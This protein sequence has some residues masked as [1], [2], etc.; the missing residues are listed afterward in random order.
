MSGGLTV[1]PVIRMRAVFSFIVGA[2]FLFCASFVLAEGLG[3]WSVE[4]GPNGEVLLAKKIS[5]G[6]EP[7]RGVSGSE[8]YVVAAENA[9]KEAG[10]MFGFERDSVALAVPSSATVR[11]GYAYVSFEQYFGS[12]PVYGAELHVAIDRKSIIPVTMKGW[13]L[14]SASMPSNLTPG[15]SEGQSK[16]IAL[17]VAKGDIG[18]FGGLSASEPKLLILPARYIGGRDEGQ[19]VL[20]YEVHVTAS[21]GGVYSPG[22]SKLYFIDAHS[23][24]VL[25]DLLLTRMDN[26]KIPDCAGNPGGT[27]CKFDVDWGAEDR[28]YP[29]DNPPGPGG[30]PFTIP[31]YPPGRG[32]HPPPPPGY[33]YPEW[34]GSLD[35]DN[36]FYYLGALN[37]Y[38]LNVHGINGMNR[39]G[40]LGNGLNPKYHTT[41]TVSFTYLDAA[42]GWLSYCPNAMYYP[43]NP[44]IYF[45][46]GTVVPDMVAHELTHGLVGWTYLDGLGRPIGML[47]QGQSGALEEGLCDIQ[48]EIFEEY[49]TGSNEE[50]IFG[51]LAR[52]GPYRNLKDPGSLIDYNITP[53]K[54][55]PD[56]FGSPNF[57]CG[58]Q[59]NYGVHHNATVPGH[60]TQLAV[61]GGD[62]NNCRISG[63]GSDKVSK[64]W[65]RALTAPPPHGFMRTETFN[66]AYVTLRNACFA[67]AQENQWP[68]S[69]C[70]NF[71]NAL[72]AVELNQPGYCTAPSGPTLCEDCEDSDGGVNPNVQG[73]V[74]YRGDTFQD[75]CESSSS[76]HEYYCVNGTIQEG[77]VSCP[78]KSRCRGG[79]CSSVPLP[80]A[81]AVPVL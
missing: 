61:Q 68:E 19:A 78:W 7:V 50:W 36:M 13:F 46:Y 70:R 38:Y 52:G 62:F 64:I 69:D 57:Y 10:E 49:Y 2:L 39:Q 11:D 24:Q 48:G 66:Q 79:K 3:K 8:D 18:G 37:Q 1:L 51:A 72:K 56:R 67:L 12:I 32:P 28:I 16:K 41:Y 20:A 34:G 58:Y 30:D 71:E 59:D 40:G 17:D 53:P 27:T 5:L 65:I 9:L 75:Y 14:S 47:Y 21:A 4:R 54:P 63:I 81:R 26:R 15:I 60:A 6:E 31:P 33:G 76:V 42:Q 74:T 43:D 22:F 77:S 35:V 44:S 55:Y 29:P 73:T 45:C 23:G 25:S 80:V